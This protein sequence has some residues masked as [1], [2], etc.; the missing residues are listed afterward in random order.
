MEP[1]VAVQFLALLDFIAEIVER[2]I[3][4]MAVRNNTQLA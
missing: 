3:R 2:F 1:R 4:A